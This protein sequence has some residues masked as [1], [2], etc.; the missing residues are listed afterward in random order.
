[1]M[2]IYGTHNFSRRTID[3]QSVHLNSTMMV[4]AYISSIQLLHTHMAEQG[5][6]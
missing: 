5:I 3:D 2:R 4:P 1:M 6:P